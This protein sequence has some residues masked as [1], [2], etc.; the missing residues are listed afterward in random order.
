MAVS[1]GHIPGSYIGQT[2]IEDTAASATK[3]IGS[4]SSGN[5]YQVYIDNTG[6]TDPVYLKI[7]DLASGSV[8]VGGGSGTH[9]DFI[10]PC[11]GS[12]TRQ[13]NFHDGLPFGTAL[14]YAVT[15]A[16]AT[17][18]STAASPTPTIRISIG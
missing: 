7:W 3:Q 13:Y 18:G 9:P 5:M 6:N 2:L 10:F 12:T 14:T 15:T 1:L 4:T 11:P 8:T 17:S 16:A